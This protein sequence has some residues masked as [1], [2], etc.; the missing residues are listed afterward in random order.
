MISLLV[1][2]IQIIE[3]ELSSILF[4][5]ASHLSEA[6]RPL[7]FQHKIF[8]FLLFIIKPHKDGAESI[9]HSITT[10]GAPQNLNYAWTGPGPTNN[11]KA[12]IRPGPERQPE[13]ES[14]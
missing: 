14:V 3:Q 11:I 1:S 12:W 7:L 5:R 10:A 8:Q 13:I 2:W 6:L 9:M 4:L